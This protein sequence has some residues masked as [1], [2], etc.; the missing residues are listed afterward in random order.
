MIS[1]P[2]RYLILRDRDCQSANLVCD[3]LVDNLL[4]ND[5]FGRSHYL[6]LHSTIINIVVLKI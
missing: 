6:N 2:D 4:T 5:N 1:V 3:G